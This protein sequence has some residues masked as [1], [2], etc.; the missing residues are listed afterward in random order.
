MQAVAAGEHVGAQLVG[1]GA[2]EGGGERALVDRTG[3]QAQVQRAAVGA[4]EVGEAVAEQPVEGAGV[5]RLGVRQPRQ[6]EP[7][8]RGDRGLVGAALRGEGDAGRRADDDEARA[9]SRG[10][11]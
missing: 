7:D 4:A 2:V 5:G 3:R 8:R 1:A 9:R 10:R 6:L 11:R